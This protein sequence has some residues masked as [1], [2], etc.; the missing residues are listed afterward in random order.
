MMHSLAA[1]T[2]EQAISEIKFNWISAIRRCESPIEEVL[3]ASMLVNGLQPLQQVEIGTRRVDFALSAAGLHFAIECDGF[4]YHDRTPEQATKDKARDRELV[5]H[6]YIPIHFTGREI[7]QDSQGCVD[8]IK[9]IVFKKVE[10]D[11]VR[12]ERNGSRWAI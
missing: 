9:S 8:Q 5:R 4:E 10:A 3:L 6:G 11:V 7:M 2:L 12:S 1:E